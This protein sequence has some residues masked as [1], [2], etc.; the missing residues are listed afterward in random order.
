[1]RRAGRRSRAR[2]YPCRSA[3]GSGAVAD[4][5]GGEG[6]PAGLVAVAAAAPGVAVVLFVEVDQVVSVWVGSVVGIVA[7]A[8]AAS[9]RDG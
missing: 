6:G 2:G 1:M 5:G 9:I 7:M 4:Q 8:R 3:G